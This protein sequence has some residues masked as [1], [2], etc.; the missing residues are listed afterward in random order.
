MLVSTSHMRIVFSVF[1]CLVTMKGFLS[2]SYKLNPRVHLLHL[3]HA[4]LCTGLPDPKDV[5][6][7][8][9]ASTL[10]CL[11]QGQQACF[12]SCQFL[13]CQ[14]GSS[15]QDTWRCRRTCTVGDSQFFNSYSFQKFAS[16]EICCLQTTHGRTRYIL[17]A[18]GVKLCLSLAFAMNR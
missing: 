11:P 10:A 17:K 13:I 1:F 16:G 3:D 18:V 12:N 15:I 14:V 4:H 2:T 8:S 6:K 9:S 5:V 7:Q